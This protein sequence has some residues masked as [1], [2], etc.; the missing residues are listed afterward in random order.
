MSVSVCLTTYNGEKFIKDQ[1]DSILCQLSDDD[2]IIVSDD[3]STDKTCQII[4]SFQDRRIKLFNH[5]VSE[6]Y[7]YKSVN[8]RITRNFENALK[9]ASGDIIF[10]ADQDDIWGKNKIQEILNLF[11]KE[12]VSLVIHDAVVVNIEMKVQSDSYFQI[13]QSGPGIIRNLIKNSYLGCCMAFDR[14]I[15]DRSLPFPENL[16]A[17][18]MWI[19]LIAE[20]YSTVRFLNKPLIQYRRH[21]LTATTSSKSSE[22]S[23]FYK[24]EYR[25]QFLL[26]FLRRVY[27][28]KK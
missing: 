9:N 7:K 27:L 26:Q 18:D 20:K 21:D 1:I 8:Y 5:Q 22:N 12:K 11:L 24:L 25:I 16:I 13:I 3:G 23:I 6:L 28:N 19:G 15:L 17:H 2:E 4:L 10:L 14:K